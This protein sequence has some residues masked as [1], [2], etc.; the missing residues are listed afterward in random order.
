M[1]RRFFN[2]RRAARRLLQ[3]LCRRGAQ[4]VRQ[5]LQ[6]VDADGDFT[7]FHRADIGPVQAGAFRQLFLAPAVQKA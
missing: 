1:C 6:I 7:P 5:S 2:T 4:R 3:K